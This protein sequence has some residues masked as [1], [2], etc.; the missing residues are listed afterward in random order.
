MNYYAKKFFGQQQSSGIPRNGLVAEWLFNGNGNDTSGNGYNPISNNAIL[1]TDRKGVLNAAYQ[2]NGAQQINYGDIL[3][4]GIG[5]LSISL[6]I[7]TTNVSTLMGIAGKNTT[8][9]ILGK[10]GI[11]MSSVTPNRARFNITASGG[12]NPF[13]T[14]NVVNTNNWSHLTI[15]LKNGDFVKWYLNGVNE[16]N[17]LIPFGN[18]TNTLPFLVGTYSINSN[19]F[20]GSIDD[21]RVYNRVLLDSEIISLYNE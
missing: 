12:D 14:S 19:Y 18:Y 17:I 2:F 8:D 11:Y 9:P 3:N 16:T 13:P 5:N 6:W 21:I 1:T 10:Y 20:I 15:V 7:K 4:I